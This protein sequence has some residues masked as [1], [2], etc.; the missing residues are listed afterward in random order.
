MLEVLVFLFLKDN[1]FFTA[2]GKCELGEGRRRGEDSKSIRTS[3]ACRGNQETWKEVV[4]QF[5]R[6]QEV[7]KLGVCGS[8]V[9]GGIKR[10][11]R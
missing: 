10:V 9:K 7:T 6:K 8:L 11:D 4:N 1:K 3:D 2:E 5:V